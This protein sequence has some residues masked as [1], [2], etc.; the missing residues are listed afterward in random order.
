MSRASRWSSQV[1]CELS[2]D[3]RDRGPG[4]LVGSVCGGSS[5]YDAGSGGRGE[6]PG[7]FAAAV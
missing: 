7:A 5:K 1:L 4:F 2:V 3:V 6:R